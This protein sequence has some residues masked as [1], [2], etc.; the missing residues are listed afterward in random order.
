MLVPPEASGKFPLPRSFW[1]LSFFLSPRLLCDEQ[2]Y[3]APISW[4]SFSDNGK[5]FAET[6]TLP[7][8]Q[9][10]SVLVASH[11]PRG[12]ILPGPGK[13][14]GWQILINSYIIPDVLNPRVSKTDGW[15]HM[16]LIPTS[17]RYLWTYMTISFKAQLKHPHPRLHSHMNPN[18]DPHSHYHYHSYT[19]R[20][21]TANTPP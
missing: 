18:P 8:F 10:K 20:N 5:I 12:P 14:H 6:F 17:A 15:L 9:N 13:K 2:F 16:R 7:N 21:P 3:E 19:H 4:S 1:I 11:S